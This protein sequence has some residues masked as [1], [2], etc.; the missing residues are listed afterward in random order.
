MNPKSLSKL[1]ALSLAAVLALLILPAVPAQA[2]EEDE[3]VRP[4]AILLAKPG[5]LVRQLQL[6]DA[7]K[8]QL[9]AFATEAKNEIKPLRDDI[10][11]VTEQIRTALEGTNPDATAIGNL[12]IDRH[13]DYEGIETSLLD[14][15]ADFS[16]ILTPT[17]L[18]K[19]EDIKDRLAHPGRR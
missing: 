14:F 2:Q 5:V 10:Q 7:Q 16:A 11:A 6:T 9:Q 17:Q 19:Y 13:D 12:V 18:T 1:V 4:I 15:D 8:T 3:A